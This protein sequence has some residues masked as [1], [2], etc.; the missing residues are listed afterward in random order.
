MGLGTRIRW[1]FPALADPS[2]TYLDSA[3]TTPVPGSVIVAMTDQ[4]AGVVGRPDR[5]AGSL[6]AGAALDRSRRTVA[7][8]LNCDARQVFFTAGASHAL[9]LVT[10]L[11]GNRCLGIGDE[12][13]YSRT[14]HTSLVRPL[15]RM[16][17]EWGAAAVPYPMGQDGAPDQ[18]GLLGRIGPRTRLV[19][20]THVHPVFGAR[21]DLPTLTRAAEKPLWLVDAGHSVGHLPIDVRELGADFLVFSGH[22]MFAPP[23]IGVLYVSPRALAELDDDTRAELE[24]GTPNTPGAVALAAAVGLLNSFGVGEIGD[25]TAGLIGR[26]AKQLR[27]IPGIWLLPGPAR[28]EASAPGALL[29]FQTDGRRAQDIADSL[30]GSGFHVRGGSHCLLPGNPFSDSV[31]VSVHAYTDDVQV[32]A[33][34][35]R[36]RHLIKKG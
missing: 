18:T 19:C 36:V 32:D 21:A 17:E 24:P 26:L 23:G 8:F 35:D 28:D 13:L 14:D 16:A 27:E 3:T 25:H 10:R 7:E 33:L 4:L 9:S 31:R 30:A 5:T 11:W 15:L 1:M 22:R 29:S 12:I 6:F 34:A 2:V 20:V